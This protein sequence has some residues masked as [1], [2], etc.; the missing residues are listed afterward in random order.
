VLPRSSRIAV[1]ALICLPLAASASAQTPVVPTP[2]KKNVQGKLTDKVEV[3]YGGPQSGTLIDP[4]EHPLA[5][6]TRIH[7]SGD[8]G[9]LND[10]AIEILDSLACKPEFFNLPSGSS[11]PGTSNA[12]DRANSISTGITCC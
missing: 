3:P 2:I 9:K 10:L 7:N 1:I 5:A 8:G 4:G 6:L 12:T 11:C